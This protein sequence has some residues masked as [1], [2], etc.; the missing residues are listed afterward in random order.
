MRMLV[1]LSSLIWTGLLAGRDVEN[2]IT[3]QV[4]DKIVA[5]NSAGYGYERCITRLVSTM[6]RLFLTPKDLIL[7]EEGMESK[8]LRTKMLPTYKANRSKRVPGQYEEFNK[9]K[10]K[11]IDVLCKLGAN[12]VTQHGVEA[13]DVIAYLSKTLDGEKMIYSADN[14]LSVL[15]GNGTHLLRD[16][17]TDDNPYGDFKH[18]YITLYKA[19]VGD[20]SDGYPGAKGFGKVAFKGLLDEFGET[21]LDAMIG[22]LEAETLSPLCED[23]TSFKPLQKILDAEETVLACWKV[24]KLYPQNVNTLESPLQW[25]VGM[26]QPFS[27]INDDRLQQWCAQSRLV[28]E[29]N[30]AE[31]VKFLQEKIEETPYFALDLETTV[32][33]DAD[34]WLAMQGKTNRVDVIAS[35]IVGCGICFG[36]N[37]QHAFYISVD[38]AETNNISIEQLDD[39]LTLLPSDRIT[40]AHNAAGFELPVLYNAFGRT[41][42]GNGWRG[43]FPNMIDTRIAA[44]YWDENTKHGLKPLTKQLIGYEQVT[45]EEVTTKNGQQVKMN[46]LTGL[47]VVA[48]GVDD[49]YTCAGLWNFFRQIME[50]EDTLPAFFAIE[51]KPMYLSALSYV[52]GNRIDQDRLNV[53]KHADEATYVNHEVTLNQYLIDV[54]W[55]GTQCPQITEITPAVLKEVVPTVLG[56]PLESRK[57][58]LDLLAEE[59]SEMGM[60]ESELLAEAI[61]THDIRAIQAMVERSY[62]GKPDF[63]VGSPKQLTHLLYDTMGLPIRLR[64]KATDTMRKAGIYEGNPKADDDAMSLAL[65]MGDA[66]GQVKAVL[67]ALTEMKSIKTRQGLYWKPYP[68]FVHWQ[69]GMIHPSLRQ[70]STNT[71][72]HSSSAPNIQ[73][74]EQGEGVRSV[75]LAHHDQ[76]VVVSCDLA[77]QEIRLLAEESRDSNMLSA[78]IGEDKKDL[79]SFTAAMIKGVS[80]EAFRAEYTSP[81]K[82]ISK[83]ANDI[84]NYGKTT[85]FASAY[86]SM[87]P[88]IALKLGVEEEVAQG[89]LDAL[90]RAFPGVNKW[91]A[92][93]E[94]FAKKHGW[95]K[96]IGGTRRHLQ[97]VINSENKWEKAKALRQASNACIQG[98]GGNQ[99]RT[100]MCRV[101]D[102]NLLDDYDFRF[103]WPV[104][105]ELVFS[106]GRKDAKEVIPLVHQMMCAQF[107]S[108]MPSASSIGIGRSFG[109][110]IE[111]GEVADPE[112]IGETVAKLF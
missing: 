111:I 11:L 73:Q 33:D 35:T 48:Y 50:I 43:F 53:L 42:K 8:S 100:I 76:A 103:Y 18:K 28:T 80:Y 47:E 105:D 97:S 5:Y 109:D 20:S 81:D 21:G 51:Q 92:Q 95:V 40:L 67:S 79:H 36:D 44:T 1:D 91:K 96:L 52:Q 98:A 45:Y 55:E 46:D 72:R 6:N 74:L 83:P 27:E 23:V 70:C 61:R 63:N 39:L 85:F 24:A 107:M 77:G 14:D 110:L 30:Y 17:G 19:L 112:L 38:H 31:S 9:L 13:D 32:P 104:H 34:I 29:Q 71:R 64:N 106:V 88:T 101:W 108:L 49:V 56:V 69:T 25:R 84:R 37:L 87:A 10:A 86:G 4:D 22:L 75:I 15:I 102:S 54:G 65:K 58:K 68:D 90:D 93:V 3:V 62:T 94:R 60:Q 16:E 12:S 78:Y 41:W 2:E 7:V 89:F 26:V 57:R 82:A 66:Q 59:I 99:I